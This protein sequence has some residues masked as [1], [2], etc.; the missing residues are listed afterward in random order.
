MRLRRPVDP[1]PTNLRRWNEFVRY[2]ILAQRP[3]VAAEDRGLPALHLGDYPDDATI[4]V[5]RRATYAAC[6]TARVTLAAASEADRFQR[7]FTFPASRARAGPCLSVR[8]ATRRS[9]AADRSGVA[10]SGTALP[11]EPL[12]RQ[13]RSTEPLQGDPILVAE[14]DVAAGAFAESMT[15]SLVIDDLFAVFRP[16]VLLY[17]TALHRDEHPIIGFKDRA[18]PR[19]IVKGLTAVGEPARG[20]NFRALGDVFLVPPGLRGEGRKRGRWI[21]A[22]ALDPPLLG[23]RG[24]PYW[25][26]GQYNL[27]RLD[28]LGWPERLV[29]AAL[30][31]T[32][33]SEAVILGPPQLLPRIGFV[34]EVARQM[35]RRL[36]GIHSDCCPEPLQ[37]LL[38][39]A[40][41]RGL[42][43]AAAALLRETW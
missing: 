31:G 13:V 39:A 10:E 34:A 4:A 9:V 21:R 19:R 3:S 37:K 18:G 16:T 29:L 2:L 41:T 30:V 27:W 35:G 5:L 38:D 28:V 1:E 26:L 11:V 23:E 17:D 20:G 12:G 24:G 6:K 22:R 8:G 15:K 42:A 7:R 43:R 25:R 36:I 14:H 40:R 32:A 33:C